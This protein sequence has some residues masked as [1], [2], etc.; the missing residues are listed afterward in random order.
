LSS[1]TLFEGLVDQALTIEG[2]NLDLVDNIAFDE[3]K[4]KVV[5]P[6]PTKL[7]GSVNIPKGTKAGPRS[8]IVTAKDPSQNFK[9]EKAVTVKSVAEPKPSAESD[10]PKG[11]R[12]G[13]RGKNEG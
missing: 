11:G 3:I 2:E 5:K 6:Q 12:P 8:M 1:T 10:A 9:V 4:F 7:E 13:R